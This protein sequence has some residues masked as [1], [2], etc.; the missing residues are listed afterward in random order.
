MKKVVAVLWHTTAS[1][2]RSIIPEV[3]ERVVLSVY[4]ARALSEGTED[5]EK[6]CRDLDTAD[7][8]LFNR[9]SGDSIWPQIEQYL[10][11]K[12][13]SGAYIGSDALENITDTSMLEVSARCNEYHT[14]SGRENMINLIRYCAHCAGD[15]SISYDPPQQTPWEGIFHPEEPER[16]YQSATEFFRNHP[17]SGKGV[18]GLLTSRANW[19][20]GDMACENEVIRLIEAAGYSVL[21]MYTYSWPEPGLGAKGPAYTLNRF[22]FDEN[23]NSIL[24]FL[25]KMTGFFIGGRNQ[26][27]NAGL[28]TRLG[29]P[30]CKPICSVNMS[31]DEWIDNPDGTIKDVAW[32]IALPELEGNIEPIFI[33]G[34]S[35]DNE[36]DMRKPVESRC[37]KL[38]ERAMKWVDL[39]RKPNEEK[40][41][42]FI[43]NNNPCASVEASVGGG[44]KLDTLESVARILHSMKKAG[45][46]LSQIPSDGKE[47]IET[48]MDRK[49]I[50]DFRWTT[51]GEIVKKGGVLYRLR[52]EEYLP[53]F[54][55][56]PEET[57]KAM[58]KTWGQPIGEE[59]D[60][61][62]PAM[63]YEDT[64]CI[65]GVSYGNALVCVQPKRGCAGSRCDGT[66]CKILHD[67]H[68]PP[69][70]QYF[71]TYR[72][73]ERIYQADVII[74]VGTHGNVEFLPGK[75]TGLSDGCFPDICIGTMP[76]LYIYNADNPPEGTI[77]KR[78]ALATIVD[79]MQTVY[80]PGGLYEDLEQIDQLVQ[81]YEQIRHTDHA[82]AHQFQHQIIDAILASKLK[83]QIKAELT[84]DNM[85][86]IVKE[87]H[88]L[89]TLIRNTQIQDGMHIFGDIPA[90]EKR[91]DLIHGI[92]RYEGNEDPGIRRLTCKLLGMD[93]AELLQNP[94]RYQPAY[95][96]T[97]G[98]VLEDVDRLGREIIRRLLEESEIDETIDP[99]GTYTI[100]APE[101][102]HEL[103]KF[104]DRVLDLNKRISASQEMENLLSAADGAYV[105]P[106]PSGVVTRGRDDVIPTGRNFYTLDPDT[107]PTKAAWVI[108]QRL[109]DAVIEKYLAD[110][111]R[112]PESFGIYWMC[113]DLLWGGG[114]GMCQMLYLMGVK[115]LWN[116]NGKV[117]AFEVIPL[118]QLGR[119]RID[120]SV[121]LSGILRDNFQ[122]RIDL[123]DRAILAV[124]QLDE[125]AEMNYVRKHTLENMA[126]GLPFEEANARLFGARPGTYL[127]GITLQIYASAW[128]ERKEMVDVYTFFNGYSY[129]SGSYGKEA[130]KVLQNSLKTVD[131]T[132]NKVM[133]DEHD[134]LGCC[135]Y[136]GVQGGMTAAA[137]ELSGRDVKPYY[138]ASREASNIQVRTMAEELGR[139][140]QSKLLNPKWIEGQ[141]RH[142]Y[143]GAGDISK[144]IGRVYGWEATT[145]E[146]GDWVFD[147]ITKTYIENQENLEFFKEN[148]PWAMEEI[149]RRLLE[150]YERGLWQPADGLLETLQES[151]L[152]IE[153]V[154]EE[155]M[156]DGSENFQGGSI[157]VKELG[158]LSAMKQHL[159]HMH[160]MLK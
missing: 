83:D 41:V 157:D 134:L 104:G 56:L 22:C 63:V 72:Y 29:C 77:A 59:I 89:L 119:P 118:E 122:G 74:H 137:R 103:G 55:E 88:T 80:I 43:L 34:T 85:D 3:S 15:M 131:I 142:G 47:L 6:L 36:Y 135:C 21:P 58:I 98:A 93:F 81:Q 126:A 155:S 66:V 150:A 86:A 84:H 46:R 53:W 100:I 31:V 95:H 109:G 138:G 156:G 129:S 64:I 124:A 57:R 127:N 26:A 128:K 61:V 40:K 5:F 70:H 132:Y 54:M 94:E 113:N 8:F 111:G 7:F 116:A 9:T 145:D 97:A 62:P 78:R 18:V 154:L 69:T 1:R 32:S 120:V 123:L 115:P 27:D 107:V 143:K 151:Y 102:L 14:Y 87:I 52:K 152:E 160:D 30:V 71:A 38:A 4:S 108:G 75:G 92:L 117:M 73:F 20:N 106:G 153:A 99:A 35:R 42:V 60:G 82:Q 44:A 10:Q 39:R 140:V 146:V 121:K 19:V 110:E 149:Q 136:Y 79:H 114:E 23:G 17:R 125:P 16:V 11:G 67:P 37:K 45:Y 158:E 133:T 50:S 33:G 159:Q 139:V 12:S 141:K 65:T 130:Y 147:E 148:N 49:A 68:C 51:V 48:I 90:G 96:K 25:I 112:Y 24:D 76:N 2:M 91:V 13:I 144:R 101:V 105:E 28:L